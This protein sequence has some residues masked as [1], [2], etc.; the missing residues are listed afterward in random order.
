MYRVSKLRLFDLICTEAVIRS[1]QAR[2]KNDQ[3]RELINMHRIIKAVV[4][5]YKDI[6]KSQK[7]KK[8]GSKHNTSK[9]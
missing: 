8:Y 9:L 6:Q 1:A 5:L 3:Y 7:L 4:R 2:N